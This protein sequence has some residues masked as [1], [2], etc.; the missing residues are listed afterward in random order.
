MYLISYLFAILQK[1]QT[2]SR[3]PYIEFVSFTKLNNVSPQ[4]E[5]YVY[6][7]PMEMVILV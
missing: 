6:T 3:Y 1:N 5:Y 7:L 2:V 4:K